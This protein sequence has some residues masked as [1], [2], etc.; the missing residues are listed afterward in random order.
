MLGAVAILSD[1]SVAVLRP[2]R[3]ARTT[4]A[5]E[6][7]W[8]Q[9]DLAVHTGSGASFYLVSCARKQRTCLR[10]IEIPAI[11]C[12]MTIPQLSE[13]FEIGSVFQ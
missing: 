2:V 9:I 10:S 13:V 12:E 7:G 3:Q 4:V 11:A 6:R 5:Y 8:T 1:V